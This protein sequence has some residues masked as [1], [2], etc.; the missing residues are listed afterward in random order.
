MQLELITGPSG[1]KSYLPIP[2]PGLIGVQKRAERTFGKEIFSY[3]PTINAKPPEK[4]IKWR[5]SVGWVN[6]L[7]KE[8]YFSL[9]RN[10]G[11]Q[12]IKAY[13]IPAN[14]LVVCFGE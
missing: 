10:A 4:K 3:S 12:I 2:D 11:W 7:N 8:E 5:Q 14:L 1:L 9:V 6:Y 13:R